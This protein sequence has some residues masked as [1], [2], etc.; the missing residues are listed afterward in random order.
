MADSADPHIPKVPGRFKCKVPL[1]FESFFNFVF[2]DE[3]IQVV[4]FSIPTADP[5]ARDAAML[6]V[7]SDVNRPIVTVPFY[8]AAIFEVSISALAAGLGYDGIRD[9][10]A[11]MKST[12][13]DLV[14]AKRYKSVPALRKDS[15]E[16]DE[17]VAFL[18]RPIP[19]PAKRPKA[20]GE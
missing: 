10:F 17:F 16:F 5:R 13:N 7:L 15:R 20:K 4:A 6:L 11:D 2:N 1:T 9:L 3:R 19:Q 14:S 8:G 12:L 18:E